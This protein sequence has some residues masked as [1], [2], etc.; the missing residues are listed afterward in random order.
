MM[1]KSSLALLKLGI[2]LTIGLSTAQAG[3]IDDYLETIDKE[4]EGASTLAKKYEVVSRPINL[5]YLRGIKDIK[6]LNEK[7]LRKNVSSDPTVCVNEEG[8]RVINYNKTTPFSLALATGKVTLVR[9]FLRVVSN[10]NGSELT[11]WGYRQPYTPAHVVLDPQYPRASQEVPLEHRL[12]IVDALGAD[13]ADFNAVVSHGLIGVYSN[14]PFAA[15]DPSGRPLDIMTQ[16]RARALLYGADPMK[17]GSCWYGLRLEKEESLGRFA[18]SYYIERAKAG[19]K[20]RPTVDVMTWL[21][22]LAAAKGVELKE[23]AQKVEEKAEQKHTLVEEKKEA[24][25]ESAEQKYTPAEELKGQQL[26]RTQRRKAYSRPVVDVEKAT[27]QLKRLAT[28]IKKNEVQLEVFKDQKTKKAKA[29]RDYIEMVIRAQ[30]E[31]MKKLNRM[32]KER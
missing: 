29:K 32:I 16:L 7:E 6:D 4:F 5:E 30:Q 17:T 25:V 8:S 31:Q 14:P 22:K 13:G 18:L 24:P 3:P 27:A 11:S 2:F 9:K 20:L 26:K 23:V 10:V 28:Q 19:A 15:G 1:K 21:K 12:M